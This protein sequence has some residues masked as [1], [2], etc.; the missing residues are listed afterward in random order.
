[1]NMFGSGG[2]RER[3]G[4]VL[5]ALISGRISG[6]RLFGCALFFAVAIL[7]PIRAMSQQDH[8]MLEARFRRGGHV[9]FARTRARSPGRPGRRTERHDKG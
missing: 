3:L 9:L 6:S 4:E 1:M 8:M 5:S 2:L 7:I